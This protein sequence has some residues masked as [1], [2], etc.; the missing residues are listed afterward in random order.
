MT[1]RS[2]RPAL[3]AMLFVVMI[4]GATFIIVQEALQDAS[5]LLFLALRFTLAAV[6]L[7]AAFAGR[8]STFPAVRRSMAAGA[9]AGIALFSGYFFQTAGLRYTSAPK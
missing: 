8:Y 2:S 9:F 1:S 7:A 5:T 3:L 6:A 4:W